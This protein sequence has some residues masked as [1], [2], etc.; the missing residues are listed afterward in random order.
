MLKLTWYN[1]SQYQADFHDIIT[2]PQSDFTIFQPSSLLVLSD[3]GRTAAEIATAFSQSTR[4]EC[5]WKRMHQQSRY[6]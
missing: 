2:R 1:S 5:E 3:V 4:S 6:G